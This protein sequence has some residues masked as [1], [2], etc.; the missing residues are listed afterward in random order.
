MNMT[1]TEN[2]TPHFAHLPKLKVGD[3]LEFDGELIVMRDAA[4]NRLLEL[5][6]KGQDFP[7]NLRGKIV[8]YAGPTFANGRMIIGP[9][10]SKRMDKYL[11]MLLENGVIATVGKGTR[12]EHARELIRKFKAPYFVA[13]SG[14]AAYLST[15][16]VS[17]EVLTFEDL[18]PE[19]IYRVE[20]KKFPLVVYIDASGNVYR[21]FG[22]AD[23]I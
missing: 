9:T 7:V 14:C 3:Y 22:G 20:V 2:V 10:T 12:S 21:P 5:K 4:Q 23:G 13:P 6:L 19:A 17:W 18:G 1:C 15:C 16:V 11:H 8:F